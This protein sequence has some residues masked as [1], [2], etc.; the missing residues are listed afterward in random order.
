MRPA[1]EGVNVLLLRM[2]AVKGATMFSTCDDWDTIY[3]Q[4][5]TE[6]AIAGRVS[7]EECDAAWDEYS[8]RYLAW[9]GYYR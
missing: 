9:D 1:C 4:L 8:T 3:L 2:R 7:R 6:L 5:L